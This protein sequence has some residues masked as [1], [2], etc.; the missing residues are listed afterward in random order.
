LLAYY[1]GAEQVDQNAGG[2]TLEPISD[3]YPNPYRYSYQIEFREDG[4]DEPPTAIKHY[5]M[6][7]TSWEDPDFQND[8]KTVY[9]CSDGDSK[10]IYKF[11]ADEEMTSVDPMDISG[12]L[13]APK[14]TNDA[15]NVEE[16]ETRASPADVDLEIEWIP[17]GSASNAECEE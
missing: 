2:T 17:L 11:V 16:S 15:A 14:I 10:G 9:G 3:I 6:G 1:L 4:D 13:Y 5:V 8:L 7:R 12:T